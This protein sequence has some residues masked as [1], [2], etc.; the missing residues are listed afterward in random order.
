MLASGLPRGRVKAELLMTDSCRIERRQVDGNGQPVFTID[1]TTGRSTPVCDT[2]YTGKCR[3]QSRGNWSTDRDIGEAGLTL[4]QT[5]LQLPVTVAPAINDRV[6][7]LTAVFNPDL[8]SD[9]Y[10]VRGDP[11]KKSNNTSRRVMLQLTTG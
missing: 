10:L 5:E 9:V 4:L 11:G 2:V 8:V 1:A 7:C 6:T 3:F